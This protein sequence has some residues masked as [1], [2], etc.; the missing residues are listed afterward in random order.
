[1]VYALTLLVGTVHIMATKTNKCNGG[2][3]QFRDKR[4]VV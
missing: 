4:F 3:V 1:M 2:K